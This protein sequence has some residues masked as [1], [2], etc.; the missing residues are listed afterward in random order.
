M[1]FIIG[2]KKLTNE[3][4]VLNDSSP[5]KKMDNI[6]LLGFIIKKERRKQSE[7]KKREDKTKNLRNS[8]CSGELDNEKMKRKKT[9][10]GIEKK[11]QEGRE[12]LQFMNSPKDE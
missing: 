5:K 11:K 8:Y 3:E 1:C 9:K 12:P 6:K 2:S 7:M 4:N 10:K